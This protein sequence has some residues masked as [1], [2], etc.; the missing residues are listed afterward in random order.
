MAFRI[1]YVQSSA[2]ELQLH[3]R[4][5]TEPLPPG[6]QQIATGV[7]S[8]VMLGPCLK[9]GS[10]RSLASFEEVAAREGTPGT[11]QSRCGA[12]GSP[13]SSPSESL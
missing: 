4:L 8:V 3:V 9:P 11:I 13:E 2:G 10:S 7:S 6:G 1:T 5:E 12:V